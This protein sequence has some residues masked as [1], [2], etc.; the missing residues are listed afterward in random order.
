MIHQRFATSDE[1]RDIRAWT[2]EHIDRCGDWLARRRL[3]AS[4]DPPASA[5][6]E[7]WDQRH[8]IAAYDA[9]PPQPAN[10]AWMC[11]LRRDLE[12][13]PAAFSGIV[14]PELALIETLAGAVPMFLP[15]RQAL[16]VP[17]RLADLLP[18]PLLDPAGTFTR[19]RYASSAWVL[20][21]ALCLH[22]GD[23]APFLDD[24]H[25]IRHGLDHDHGDTAT[26]RTA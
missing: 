26:R 19:P 14:P 10:R 12:A 4:A 24:S 7:V 15:P 5:A 20:L 25:F 16:Y 13:L 9:G 8:M 18:L 17:Y 3:P 23:T 11:L 2:S 21:D 22:A 1:N 6:A